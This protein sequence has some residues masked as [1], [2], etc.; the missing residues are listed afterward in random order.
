MRPFVFVSLVAL[1]ACNPSGFVRAPPLGQLYFPTGIQWLDS[2]TAPGGVLYVASSNFD[3]R[4][5][6]G[7]LMAIRVGNLGL[8]TF[9]AP[10]PATGPAII[11]DLKLGPRAELYIDSFAGDVAAFLRPSG[12]R[13]FVPTRTEGD[14][15]DVIDAQDDVLTCLALA[16]SEDKEC[17]QVSPSLSAF[18]NVKLGDA[19]QRGKPIAPGLSGV[20]VSPQGDLFVAHQEAAYSPVG[21]VRNAEAYLVDLSAEN[22]QQIE[23]TDF[24]SIA[25]G[26]DGF[27]EG[28]GSSV[29]V[30]SRWVFVS[31]RG[32][33]GNSELLRLVDR[34]TLGGTSRVVLSPGLQSNYT[35]VEGRGMALSPDQSKLYIVTRA[36]DR[37]LQVSINGATGP[38]PTL[39]IDR[40]I[41]L[42]PGAN[43]VVRVE[44]ALRGALI[45]VVCPT[46]N[47]ITVYDEDLGEVV[48]EYSGMGIQPTNMAV[49]PQGA[50]VRLF[51]TAFSS[52]TIAVV[53]VPDLNAPG[54]YN[55]VAHLGQC[56]VGGKDGSC[57]GTP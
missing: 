56:T 33:S 48:R 12:P 20:G 25:K 44:R 27:Y 7:T 19:Y 42:P 8:P 24:T 54:N 37:L 29:Q 51:V 23:P 10:V 4:Y 2:A 40:D 13:L 55:V 3:K 17:L 32:A 34:T 36:P 41:V 45:F 28:G 46:A 6:A 31:G 9:G 38:A 16:P 30:G 22:P 15:L 49:Q 26:D 53:D 11:T 14:F 39:K 52:G 47:L 18:W 1:A 21:S 5:D 57:E 43:Q 50:G 35:V